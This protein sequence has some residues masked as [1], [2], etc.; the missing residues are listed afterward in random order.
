[1]RPSLPM[2]AWTW[3]LMTVVTVLWLGM[4][5]AVLYLVSHIAARR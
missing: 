2:N 1:M 3:I 4:A 5:G